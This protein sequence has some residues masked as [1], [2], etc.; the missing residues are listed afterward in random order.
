MSDT[1][2]IKIIKK[3]GDC[4]YC[5]ETNDGIHSCY[6]IPAPKG[7]HFFDVDPDSPPPDDCP[8]A[9]VD[10]MLEKAH[11]ANPHRGNDIGGDIGFVDGVNAVGAVLKG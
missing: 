7:S 3:C 2:R 1:A 11:E 6:I 9:S 10:K 5:H 4:S 8:L